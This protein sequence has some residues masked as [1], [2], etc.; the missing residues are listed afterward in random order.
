MYTVSRKNRTPTTFWQ[1]FTKK[2]Q[3]SIIFDRENYTLSVR[4]PLQVT[5]LMLVRTT[6]N[7]HGNDIR[8]V[9]EL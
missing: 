3:M 6:C 4:L 1:G 2:A 5:S 9:R 8:Y 7:F